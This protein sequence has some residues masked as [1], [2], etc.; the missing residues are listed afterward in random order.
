MGSA[1]VLA[2]NGALGPKMGPLDPKSPVPL[3]PPVNSPLAF[4]IAVGVRLASGL[5]PALGI[6]GA[7]PPPM[8]PPE[9]GLGIRA[10]WLDCGICGP[11]IMLINSW[12]CCT[13]A[14][15]RLVPPI[16]ADCKL[17]INPAMFRYP[18]MVR[19]KF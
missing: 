3:L 15:L 7:W 5:L 2:P 6:V 11:F 9:G 8:P 1:V 4:D 19:M 14:G 10:G 12:S 17:S 13:S 18:S 16:G